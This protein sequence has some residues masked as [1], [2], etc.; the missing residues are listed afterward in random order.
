[1]SEDEA[2]IRTPFEGTRRMEWQ[3]GGELPAPLVLYRSEVP[4]AWVDYNDHMSESSYLLAFGHSADAFF[5]FIG[6]DEDYR[7]AGHSLFTVETHIHNISQARKGDS[8][9]L[10]LTV[11]D[12]DAKRVHIMHTMRN[13]T[14]D[15]IVAAG[16]QLLV[17]VDTEIGRS[18]AMGDQLFERI[19]QLQHAHAGLE[20]PAFIGRPL[21]IR[22][23]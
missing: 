14:T 6:I 8:F 21:G 15:E 23:S 22:R 1:M 11:L 19:S 9:E 2:R 7:A 20:R 13:A 18:A 17:H 3:G 5:R 12:V 10:A 4:E 16:E